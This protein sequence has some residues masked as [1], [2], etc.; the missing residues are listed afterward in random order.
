MSTRRANLHFTAPAILGAVPLVFLATVFI[1]TLS[2]AAPRSAAQSPDG[3]MTPSANVPIQVPP[4]SQ[5]GPTKVRV[6]QIT[7]PVAVY[8][9]KGEMIHDLNAKDFRISDSGIPQQIT[10]FDLGSESISMVILIENSSRVAP[11]LPTLRRTGTLF[12][13]TVL[14]PRGEAAVVSFNDGIDKLQDFTTDHDQIES[15]IAQI[16]EGTRGTKLFDAMSIGVEMLTARP[17]KAADIPTTHRVL[18][19]V[20]EAVDVGSSVQLNDVLRQAELANVTIYTVGLSTVRGMAGSSNDNRMRTN[21]PGTIGRPTPPG[22][23]DTPD[24]RDAMNGVGTGSADLAGLAKIVLQQTENQ[25]RAHPLQA[26]AAATG[27]FHVDTFKDRS[28]EKAID[29]IGGELHTQY[30]ISYTPTSAASGFHP[31]IVSVDQK[32]LTVRARPGY[33]L[34]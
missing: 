23:I 13:Q 34:P 22:T 19:I 29:E 12:T 30:N 24:N 18:M 11:L 1:V 21:P 8:N 27:G 17:P 33:Y 3:P 20:A 4:P 10:H 32:N 25:L 6:D 26:A 2:I 16:P 15:A 5:S 14:G 28:I 7:T 31:I 9:K